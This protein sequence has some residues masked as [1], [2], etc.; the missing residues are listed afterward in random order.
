[1][2]KSSFVSRFMFVA[3]LLLVAALPSFAANTV[4]SVEQV[5][6]TVE[7]TTD[8]DYVIT[9]ETPFGANGVVNI[10]N[11]DHAVVIFKTVKPSAV[12]KLLSKNVKINGEVKF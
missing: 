2:E 3:F 9:G 11:T 8:V 1:M 6:S 7:L 10:I 12:I 5:T 4:T